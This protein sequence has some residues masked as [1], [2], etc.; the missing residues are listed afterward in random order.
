MSISINEKIKFEL[1]PDLEKIVESNIKSKGEIREIIV[2]R[3]INDCSIIFPDLGKE[4]II[5]T[6]KDEIAKEVEKRKNSKYDSDYD[7][8]KKDGNVQS[9]IERIII[10]K[11]KK[12]IED[13]FSKSELEEEKE[14]VINEI[15][16]EYSDI[17]KDLIAQIVNKNI[18]REWIKLRVIKP[19]MELS[20]YPTLNSLEELNDKEFV[21][22]KRKNRAKV[23]SNYIIEVKKKQLSKFSANEIKAMT[24]EELYDVEKQERNGM[25]FCFDEKDIDENLKE[26]NKEQDYL[27]RDEYE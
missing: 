20:V 21:E 26:F 16:S 24:L 13:H 4:K 17:D 10:K 2:N 9:Q 18:Y 6:I 15:A 11:T 25:Y 27:G 3:F 1:I 14:S 5:F 7:F 8:E 23:I 12:S 19:V 22:N